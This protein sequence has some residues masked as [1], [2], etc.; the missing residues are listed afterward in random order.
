MK[1]I[2][3]KLTAN[4]NFNNERENAFPL[5]PAPRTRLDCPFSPCLFNNVLEVIASKIRI[6]KKLKGR[7]NFLWLKMT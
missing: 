5:G 3:E 4:I 2:Y 6:D 1:D 7:Q